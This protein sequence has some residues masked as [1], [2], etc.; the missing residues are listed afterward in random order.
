MEGDDGVAWSQASWCM[1]VKD[2]KK[3]SPNPLWSLAMQTFNLAQ[4]IF[5][6]SNGVM[7]RI[8]DAV[9]HQ[10][11]T[12]T[13][14][15]L[16]VQGPFSSLMGPNYGRNFGP[17]L[18]IQKISTLEFLLPE[19]QWTSLAGDNISFC[20]SL[21]LLSEVADSE[22]CEDRLSQLAVLA[23]EDELIHM[24]RTSCGY[25]AIA[26]FKL[27][28]SVLIF[29]PSTDAPTIDD[30]Q[31]QCYLTPHVDN[32][33]HELTRAE[34]RLG[35]RIKRPSIST[36]YALWNIA[37]QFL[38][39]Q[40]FSGRRPG[41]SDPESARWCVVLGITVEHSWIRQAIEGIIASTALNAKDFVVNVGFNGSAECLR[42]S[43][44]T[45]GVLD[46]FDQT[47]VCPSTPYVFGERCSV[48]VSA[49]HHANS[50][51]A[52]RQVGGW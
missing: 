6:L 42:S 45:N 10:P 52:M 21:R 33:D 3:G 43:I 38:V 2:F 27:P 11:V 35:A 4:S 32:V 26:D 8:Y 37:S 23:H 9:T 49:W 1:G 22:L 28:N 31:F 44:F 17:N 24:L 29:E 39:H 36:T 20:E 7:Y 50:R 51:E 41:C 13:A 40:R 48:F 34:V 30:S 5:A 19:E 25:T 16:H 18:R 47:F 14:Y 15:L 46:V 12:E